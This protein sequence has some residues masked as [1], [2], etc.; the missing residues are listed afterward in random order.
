[1]GLFMAFLQEVGYT[2]AYLWTTSELPAAASM[3][4]KNGFALV[5]ERPAALAV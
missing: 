2:A 1:M 4:K 3:H 5:E